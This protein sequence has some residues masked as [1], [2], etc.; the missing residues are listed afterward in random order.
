LLAHAV[1]SE[2]KSFERPEAVV[3]AVVLNCGVLGWMQTERGRL[4]LRSFMGE[5]AGMGPNLPL[6]NLAS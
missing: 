3:W 6:T 2:A 4:F 5:Y 1:V